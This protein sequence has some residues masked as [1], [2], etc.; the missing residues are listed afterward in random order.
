MESKPPKRHPPKIYGIS[1]VWIPAHFQMTRPRQ[2]G[3]GAVHDL[4]Q[5]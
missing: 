2:N 4:R 3:E 5:P 1:E